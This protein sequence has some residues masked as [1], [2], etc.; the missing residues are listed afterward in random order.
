MFACVRNCYEKNIIWYMFCICSANVAFLNG[1]MIRKI[2]PPVDFGRAPGIAVL[3][4]GCRSDDCGRK[5]H[6]CR[7]MDFIPSLYVVVL[8]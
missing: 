3:P 5:S 1:A 7:Y 6:E 8:K 4:G 2:E